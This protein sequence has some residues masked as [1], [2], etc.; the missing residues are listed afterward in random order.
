MP[1]SS[2]LQW[3]TKL[4]N[5]LKQYT[6]FF[7]LCNVQ[8]RWWTALRYLS[9][10]L[11]S[12][13]WI[14]CPLSSSAVWHGRWHAGSLGL[15]TSRNPFRVSFPPLSFG[16]EDPATLC[17][18]G[19]RLLVNHN[20]GRRRWRRWRGD[21]THHTIGQEV[22]RRRKSHSPCIHLSPGS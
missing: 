9:F 15:L 7:F 18:N 5:I 21:F 22:P 3:G 13:A 20:R 1:L 12:V 14:V 2:P 16:T 19:L 8:R 4:F 6:L 17:F 10:Y 11:K